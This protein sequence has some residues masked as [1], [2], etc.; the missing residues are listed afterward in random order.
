MSTSSSVSL[1]G[2]IRILTSHFYLAAAL[3]Q[4]SCVPPA[5]P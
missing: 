3:N 2:K 4:G 5:T 1:V